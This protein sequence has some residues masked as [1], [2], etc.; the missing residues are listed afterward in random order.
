MKEKEF[1]L[2]HNCGKEK[3][4]DL[5]WVDPAGNTADRIKC[6]ICG[7]EF[8]DMI[9]INLIDIDFSEDWVRSNG[10]TFTLDEIRSVIKNR[11]GKEL[12]RY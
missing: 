9:F 11:A 12:I 2:R 6:N 1:N 10:K 4:L 8:I 3:D 7:K 5:S